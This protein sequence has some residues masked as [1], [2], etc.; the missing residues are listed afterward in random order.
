MYS[1][2]QPEWKRVVI[3]VDML[4]PYLSVAGL[5]ADDQSSTSFP[6]MVLTAYIEET[7]VLESSLG[8]LQSARSLFNSNPTLCSRLNL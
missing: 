4:R 8:C 3:Q 5:C 7:Q 1:H 6:V 2:C